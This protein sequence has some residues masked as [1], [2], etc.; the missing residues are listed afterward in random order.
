MSGP[1]KLGSDPSLLPFGL[2]CSLSVF[3][4]CLVSQSCPTLRDLMDCSLPGSSVHEISQARILE[5]VAISCSRG[6]S[7]PRGGA[8]VSCIGRWILHRQRHLESP[9]QP[10]VI[11]RSFASSHPVGSVWKE[12]EKLHHIQNF[13]SSYRLTLCCLVSKS[14]LTLC[15][16]VDCGPSGSSAHGI[17]QVRTFPSPGDLP[18][19]GIK[20][21]SPALAGGF[22]T[23]EPP[24]EPLVLQLLR[25]C[26][27]SLCHFEH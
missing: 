24:G 19:P 3:V 2:I 25:A 11:K 26:F 15:D 14:C 23:T 8:Q 4:L 9:F 1:L 27:T 18:N 13:L 5:W 20:P 12:R 17:S 7:Q 16:P 6:S 10:L 21:M 22:F